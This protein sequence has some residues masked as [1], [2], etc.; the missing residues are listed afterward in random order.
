M[1]SIQG[2]E[3]GYRRGLVLGLTMAEIVILV[4]F[5][6]LLVLGASLALKERENDTLKKRNEMLQVGAI[7]FERIVRATGGNS[8]EIIRVLAAAEETR[9][10]LARIEKEVT[11]LRELREDIESAR[12]DGLP[13][14][15][16]PEIF[17]ELVL[18]RDAVVDSGISPTPDSIRQ[19]LADT[20]AIKEELLASAGQNELLER[21]NRN[22]NT[23]MTDLLR[24]ARSGGRGLDHPPCWATPDGKAEYIFDIALTRRGL[25]VRERELPH[26]AIERAKLPIADLALDD[27]L[28]PKNFL[29]MTEPLFRWSVDSECRFVVRAFDSTA[30]TEKTIYK[31]H[32]RVLEQRFY[33]YEELNETF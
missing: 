9:Q 19:A 14:R 25:I 2:E 10:R 5:V 18:V 31:R 26:R 3:E 20:A 1:Y 28:I 17:R 7:Q 32:M 23:K 12:P 30:P 21:Q 6:L 8:E 24:Q 27:E 29:G 33:K 15:P 22:L 4:I 16:L 11:Q 13:E